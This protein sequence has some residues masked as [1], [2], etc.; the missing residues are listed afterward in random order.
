VHEKP[1]EDPTQPATDELCLQLSDVNEP[2]M[3]Q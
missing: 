2:L 3:Q 1:I